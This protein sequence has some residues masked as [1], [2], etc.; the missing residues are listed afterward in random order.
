LFGANIPKSEYGIVWSSGKPKSKIPKGV[1]SDSN[2][3]DSPNPSFYSSDIWLR[4][5]KEIGDFVEKG[6]SIYAEIVGKGIQGDMYTYNQDYGIYVYRIT[7]TNVDGQV[8][9]FS[10]EQLQSYCQKYGLNHV[11]EYFVGKVKELVVFDDSLLGY[12]QQKYLDKSYPDCQI[13]EGICIRLRETEE[14]FKL[15][16]PN[17]ILQENKAQEAGETNLEDN[18]E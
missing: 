11:E 15:K 1:E 5:Y 4:A 12:L 13:D 6:I 3:W 2:K 17:F 8:Y 18:Q 10:W 9:E 14:I 7:S 16:S